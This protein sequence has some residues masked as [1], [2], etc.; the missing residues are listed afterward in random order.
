LQHGRIVDDPSKIK[1]L[2]GGV[3]RILQPVRS[4]SYGA[5]GLWHSISLNEDLKKSMFSRFYE[6]ENIES[7]LLHW[8]ELLFF[9][10]VFPIL[11]PQKPPST[12]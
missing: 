8:L 3:F 2:L 1:A 10:Q 7:S 4:C 11:R 12:S 5:N 9:L 6:E